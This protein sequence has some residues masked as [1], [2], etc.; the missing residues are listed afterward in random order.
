MLSLLVAA[1]IL[2]L[3]LALVYYA[4][5]ALG[6]PGNMVQIICIVILIVG[7]IILLQRAGVVGS[8]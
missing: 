5:N 1:L 7:V 6:V 4:G 8:L 2:L 3:V